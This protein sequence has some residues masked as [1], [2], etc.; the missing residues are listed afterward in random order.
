MPGPTPSVST[1]CQPPNAPAGDRRRTSSAIFQSRSDF[2][3]PWLSHKIGRLHTRAPLF[4][5][6]PKP[7][8]SPFRHLTDYFWQ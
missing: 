5:L 8:I 6:P 3:T 7:P 1:I 4:T 2:T